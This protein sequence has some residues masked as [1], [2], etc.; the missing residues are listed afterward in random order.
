MSEVSFPHGPRYRTAAS[1]GGRARAVPHK[2]QRPAWPRSVEYSI[3]ISR[4]HWANLP[5]LQSVLCTPCDLMPFSHASVRLKRAFAILAM[6]VPLSTGPALAQGFKF[7]QPDESDRM[8]K[9]ARED[10]MA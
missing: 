2:L 3:W 4:P 1:P 10:R 8:E 5:T 6:L 9:E 7:S